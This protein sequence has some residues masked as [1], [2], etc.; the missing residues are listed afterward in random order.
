[1]I[2]NSGATFG[3]ADQGG[4]MTTGG[5]I[6]V[7]DQLND[8]GVEYSSAPPANAVHRP[9]F[10]G[11]RDKPIFAT[12]SAPSDGAVRAAVLVCPPLGKE[13][14]ET[15]RALRMLGDRLAR[16]RVAA[17]RIDYRNTG[18]S[19]GAQT[20]PDATDGWLS[21]IVDGVEHLRA[22]GVSTVGIIGLRAGALLMAQLHD[23]LSTLD[24]AIFWDPVTKGR[25]M[26]R[27]KSVLYR[28]VS[29]DDGSV[30]GPRPE[31]V[32][33][34]DPDRVHVAGQSLSATAAA[35]FGAMVFEPVSLAASVPARS[36]VLMSE[37]EATGPVGR[38]LGDTELDV[39]TC[40]A[41]EYFLQP[42]HPG[43]LEF[44]TAEIDALVEWI[45]AAAGGTLT[46]MDLPTVGS[47]VSAVIGCSA[48]GRR[49]ETRVR[50]VPGT[51]EVFWDTAIEGEHDTA[52]KVLVTYSLGQYVRTGPGRM[53]REAAEAV[54]AKGGRAIR[55]DRLGVGES[56]DPSSDDQ[57]L[58]LHTR[59]FVEGAA[60]ILP[61]L[62]D[63]P[64]SSTVVH[65]G[66]CVGSWAAAHTAVR[67]SKRRADLH[68]VVVM[69]NPLM[70]RAWPWRADTTAGDIGVGGLPGRFRE[71]SKLDNVVAKLNWR[72]NTAGGVI[73][74]RLPRR[75]HTLA[76]RLPFI[77]MP[78]V[79]FERFARRGITASLVFSPRDNAYFVSAFGGEEAIRNSR[80]RVSRRVAPT[81]DHTSYHRFMRHA[82]V[83][84]VVEALWPDEEEQLHQSSTGVIGTGFQWPTT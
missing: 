46:T 18:E 64:A 11:G 53:W 54:A 44:P 77:Q 21:S 32:D 67:G 74:R 65:A 31:V 51:G 25:T 15:T 36:V 66:I 12:L 50:T 59:S 33:D 60:A 22:A 57:A 68:Q 75:L 16:S 13:Q 45:D 17:L 63:L 7:A 5:G 58:S 23:L 70:W 28:M 1:M 30:S 71:P 38:A 78:E 82:A 19:W 39:M 24:F 62:D 56:G 42:S 79:M 83:S 43:Y 55:F 52:S 40:S 3:V 72:G 35:A 61:V 9:V 47:P 76:G 27:S 73:R 34:S 84:A 26:I 29:D 49:I 20:A 2:G 81:G 80:L 4:P 41:S 69:V 48:D 14:A 37:S 8:V 6:G 10:I